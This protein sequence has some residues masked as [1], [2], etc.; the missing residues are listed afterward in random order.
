MRAKALMSS[1]GVVSCTRVSEMCIHFTGSCLAAAIEWAC[2]E[3]STSSGGL[4]GQVLF[5]VGCPQSCVQT[6]K[7]RRDTY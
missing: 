3:M 5:S 4:A 7:V 6:N 1:L 2:R